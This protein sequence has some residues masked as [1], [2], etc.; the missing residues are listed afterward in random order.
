MRLREQKLRD[1]GGLSLE[2]Y[3]RDQF[4]ED[5]LLERCAE[6][7]GLEARIHELDTLL[8]SARPAPGG[9]R[10]RPLRLRR[11]AAVGLPLLRE[12]RPAGRCRGGREAPGERLRPHPVARAATRPCAAEPGVLPGVRRPARPR[13]AGR[14]ARTRTSAG[15]GQRHGWA[16]PWVVPALLG[17]VIAVLGTGAAI[18]ISS[19]GEEPSAIST[20]TGG[21]LTVTNDGSDADRARAD[22][23]RRRRRHRDDDGT[24]AD[25]HPEA[26]GEPGGDRLAPRPARLDDRAPLAPAGERAR[27]RQTPRR[28]R[29]DAAASAASAS[30][31]PARYASLHPGYYVIFT[32]VFDSRGGGGERAP[33]SAGRLATARRTS[34]RS[35]RSR[36]RG[37][38]IR[39]AGQTRSERLGGGTDSFARAE[40]YCERLCNSTGCPYTRCRPPRRNLIFG[41][42]T[43][44]NRER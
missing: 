28:L 2:M 20:A 36:A 43:G 6:L 22:R 21:S 27:A 33:A 29:R 32:G 4:R 31:T 17:L 8:G 7:I 3:R 10:S 23:A 15:I 9:S 1:L 19:D 14:A 30:S 39:R 12:L 16:G 35:S 44:Q 25:D 42:C 11:A 18:A 41:L 5:L 34:A 37:V 13:A 24:E 26:A 38:G 40:N